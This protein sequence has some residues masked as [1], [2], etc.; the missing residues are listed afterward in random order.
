MNR[1][2]NPNS[3][4]RGLFVRVFDADKVNKANVIRQRFSETEVGFNKAV[5]L[6]N[7]VNRDLA[8]RGKLFHINIVK[9]VVI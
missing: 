4:N 6:V 8:P 7:K 1:Q 3:N 5:I 2:N 9:R